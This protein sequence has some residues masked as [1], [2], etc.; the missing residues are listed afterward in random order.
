MSIKARMLFTVLSVIGLLMM[1]AVPAFAQSVSLDI[2]PADE[3]VEGDEVVFTATAVGFDDPEYS[4]LYRK[5][6]GGSKV[7]IGQRGD[8][9]T[10]APTAPVGS[11]GLWDFAVQVR[12][13]GDDSGWPGIGD[14]GFDWFQ[15]YEIL[16][17]GEPSVTL[18][19]EPA[20]SAVEGQEVTF[21]AESENVVNPEYRFI[22]RAAGGSKLYFPKT[23][24]DNV[25]IRT[26]PVGS[27]GTWDFGVQVREVGG[28]WLD[29]DIVENYVITEDVLEV[30]SVAAID[31][32]SVE[33]GT[34][35]ADLPLP[36]DVDVTFDNNSTISIP[37][38]WDEGDYDGEVEGD[39]DLEGELQLGANQL[40]PENKK[41]E[42]TVTVEEEVL[43]VASVEV[44]SADTV[45]VTFQSPVKDHMAGAIEFSVT[46]PEDY[47]G[48]A[49]G[50]VE[51]DDEDALLT[52][53]PPMTVDGTYTLDGVAYFYGNYQFKI[54]EDNTIKAGENVTLTM[55]NNS[56]AV[57]DLDDSADYRF[58][59]WDDEN[60]QWNAW[61]TWNSV[62]CEEEVPAQDEIALFT[63]DK[64][65]DVM[66]EY[67]L[68]VLLYLGGF[69]A[70]EVTLDF[71]V[72]F[73][74]VDPES[75]VS[76]DPDELTVGN[77]T[78]VTV[79]LLDVE[80]NAYTGLEEDDFDISFDESNIASLANNNNN[81]NGVGAEV[82][83][84]SF[85]ED[86][87]EPGTYTF[88]VYNETAETVIV[89]VEVL[90]VELD[91]KP[92]IEFLAD[93]A[94]KLAIK[95]QPE[96]GL[97][98]EELGNLVVEAQDQYGNATSKGLPGSKSVN[99]SIDTGPEGAEL[100]GDTDKNIGTA[101]GSG[102]VT[103]D[104][105][106]LDKLGTYKLEFEAAALGSVVS[107]DIEVGYD[108][109]NPV[110]LYDDDGEYMSKH[111]DIQSAIDAANDPGTV[112]V[113]PG[114]YPEDVTVNYDGLM[115][116]SVEKHEAVIEG[117][118]SII[119]EDVVFENF[120]VDYTTSTVG[121]PIDLIEFK[122]LI[123]RGNKVEGGSDTDG[124]NATTGIAIV[125]GDVIIED[126]EIIKGSIGLILSNDEADDVTIRNNTIS[127]PGE[128]G[129]WVM[130]NLQAVLVIQG[131][132]VTDA[133]GAND[134]K[135]V[136]KPLSINGVTEEN[137][138]EAAILADNTIAS[139]LLEWLE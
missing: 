21:T 134:V 135:I 119:A 117:S 97:I 7:Y 23:G 85:A 12:E 87:E 59:K 96:E 3:C 64:V 103:F 79:E 16:P 115:L 33:Y 4:F 30:V 127:E 53:D 80:G 74:D 19:I 14:P 31:P 68:D 46:G 38:V 129:I 83:D 112:L 42:V 130:E 99:V 66:G 104:D 90:E 108:E 95:E 54:N 124:I 45:E 17:P 93:T 67:Q 15:D 84:G 2:D 36:E 114:T 125:S 73:A 43:K 123:I 94:V 86:P 120:H 116:K 101:N 18:T 34:L 63:T 6:G 39:Y 132:T 82:V 69:V 9:S 131:N 25:W 11:A 71:T 47:Q 57:V 52:L 88:E 121:T 91:D 50:V 26:A 70:F 110:Y 22:Y 40:N 105:L 10:W 8:E 51:E 62:A 29:H 41:A 118:V 5:A 76:V 107:D 55:V 89:T 37:V 78:T 20:G 13:K 133:G 35:F 1:M 58:R 92:G 72:E 111:A 60:E 122:G 65:F 75:K 102:E 100:S 24:T 126:N 56:A 139:V 81:D 48:T 113:Y 138:M 32:I 137:D 109:D 44:I 28:S 49:S 106:S 27:A 128:E 77:A 98:Y 136:D 61:S